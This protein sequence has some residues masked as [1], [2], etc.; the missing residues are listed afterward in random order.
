MVYNEESKQ[1]VLIDI[2]E[3]TICDH[4]HKRVIKQTEPYSYLCYPNFFRA[5]Q[6]RELYTNLQMVA[7]FLILS[8]MFEPAKGKQTS[9]E[10]LKDA[11]MGIDNFLR[12]HNDKDFTK[13]RASSIPKDVSCL[14][15]LLDKALSP[16]A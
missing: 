14:V 12:L 11:A 6:F 16:V 9:L 10:I 13:A 1:L 2:D 4:A 3:G 7:S 5:W 8:D 15:D